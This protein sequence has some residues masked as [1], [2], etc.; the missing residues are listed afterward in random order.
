MVDIL[1]P[2]LSQI[3][4]HLYVAV[5]PARIRMISG[6]DAHFA[7][8]KQKGILIPP[9]VVCESVILCSLPQVKILLQSLL[10]FVADC[11][12]AGVYLAWRHRHYDFI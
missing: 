10:G 5:F 1:A 7:H 2:S 11:S 6:N 9:K 8:H 3:G 4:G 12:A